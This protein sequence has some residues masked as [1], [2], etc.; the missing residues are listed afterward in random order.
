MAGLSITAAWNETTAFMA[1]EGRLVLPVGFMLIALPG[2]IIQAATPPTQPNELPEPGLWLA[3]VPF[4]IAATLI[5]N[6]AISVLALRPGSSV[7][8]AIQQGARRFLPVLGA[9]LLIGLATMLALVPVILLAAGAAVAL[10]NPAIAAL[11]VLLIIPFLVFLWI[12]LLLANP[13]GAVERG[14]P[15]A[16]LKRSWAL[17][18]GRFWPLLGFLV[19]LM[20]VA[21]VASGAVAAVG[22]T[23]IALLVGPPRPDSLSFYLVLILSALVQ[24]ALASV[25]G[26]MVARIY[27]QLAP[28][29]PGPLFS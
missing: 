14:G 9:A 10:G 18:A 24:A 13:I 8:E 20:I 27:A 2:A 23:L 3:L 7:G 26:V 5:G 29:D 21:L 15:V 22:G 4:A 11:P 28:P 1:R 19:L 6:L 17:T 12:R 16:I 25:F